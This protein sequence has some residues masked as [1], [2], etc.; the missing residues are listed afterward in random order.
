[1][2]NSSSR[3]RLHDAPSYLR[4]QIVSEVRTVHQHRWTRQHEYENSLHYSNL[5]KLK[6]WMIS[7]SDTDEGRRQRSSYAATQT[8]TQ[9]PAEVAPSKHRCEVSSKKGRHDPSS[10]RCSR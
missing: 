2:S 8:L 1:M 10:Q 5:A 9:N 3:F 4:T 6:V 7:R